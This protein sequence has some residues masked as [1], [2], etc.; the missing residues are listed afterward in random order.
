MNTKSTLFYFSCWLSW[1]PFLYAFI[2]PVAVI[3]FAN[4]IVF[5]MVMCNLC[6]RKHKGMVSNQSEKKMAF[7]HFQAGVSILVILG[8][9]TSKDYPKEKAIIKKRNNNNNK[10]KEKQQQVILF[11]CKQFLRYFGQSLA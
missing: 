11:H 4:S 8:E 10:E 2:I 7:L 9:Y 5:L 6:R 1:K 3:I